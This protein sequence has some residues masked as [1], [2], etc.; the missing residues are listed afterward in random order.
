MPESKELLEKRGREGSWVKKN[1]NLL[2]W[3]LWS[4]WDNLI[5]K[6]ISHGSEYRTER[7]GIHASIVN[8]QKEKEGDTVGTKRKAT[9][10][11]RT[12]IDMERIIKLETQNFKPSM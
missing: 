4:S 11:K 9:F 5:I 2:N 1:G 12:L 6:K 3:L 7:E 10:Y 8:F